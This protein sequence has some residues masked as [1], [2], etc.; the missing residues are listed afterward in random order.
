MNKSIKKTS[1]IHFNSSVEEEDYYK[2]CTKCGNFS[3]I[4]EKQIYCAICGDEF[5]ENCPRCG[6]R[7]KN[8][9]AKFCVKCGNKFHKDKE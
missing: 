9:T 2:L 5:I 6:E 1:N 3:H 8:P 4:N 7:I